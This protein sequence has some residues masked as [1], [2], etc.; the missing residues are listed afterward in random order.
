[1]TIRRWFWL[2]TLSLAFAPFASTAARAQVDFETP[3]DSEDSSDTKTEAK[4]DSTAG[5][6]A[7]AGSSAG[8]STENPDAYL[9][10][11]VDA[12][13]AKLFE[14]TIKLHAEARKIV[15][16]LV[17]KRDNDKL[18]PGAIKTVGAGRVAVSKLTRAAKRLQWWSEPTG[19]DLEARATDLNFQLVA[20]RDYMRAAPAISQKIQAL[21]PKL[22]KEGKKYEKDIPK[23]MKMCDDEKWE[24]AFETF[25]KGKDTLDRVGVWFT[26]DELKPIYDPFAKVQERVSKGLPIVVRTQAVAALEQARQSELAAA[27]AFLPLL[28]QAATAVGQTGKSKFDGALELTG[29]QIVAE[30]GLRWR[31]AQGSFERARALSWGLALTEAPSNSPPGFAPAAKSANPVDGEHSQFTT[32]VLTALSQ[33]I[34][35]DAARVDAAG[36]AALHREYVAAL[37][38]LAAWVGDAGTQNALSAALAGFEAKVPTLAPYRLATSE[39]LRW[40]ER[41]A[42][43]NARARLAAYPA[44]AAVCATGVQRDRAKKIFGLIDESQPR[45]LPKF[46]DPTPAACLSAGPRLK[47]KP[48]SVVDL[49]QG[50]AGT[51]A[52]SRVMYRCQGRATIGVN[53]AA[54][55]AALRKELLTAA[56]E[57]PLSLEAAAAL[58]GAEHGLFAQ[59]GGTI[60]SAELQAVVTRRAT[61]SDA[62]WGLLR[63][64][65]LDPDVIDDPLRECQVCCRLKLEWVRNKYFV[66]ECP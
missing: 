32:Q 42:A 40:R 47:D 66:A 27:K 17:E 25:H 18:G 23:V 50:G 10:V 46:L 49:F 26:P 34:T 12:T 62:D 5:V 19:L 31:A 21:L 36:A 60:T 2:A 22:A 16:D 45:A 9:P 13:V 55:A 37:A 43:A 30:A 52:Q 65:T 38:P 56:G 6:T 54:Q 8:P 11:R 61:A 51:E 53:V 41:T 57:A 7:P 33:L 20:V 3:E 58:Y 59:A 29:P 64:G 39:L 35:A 14:E 24:E 4:A 15:L 63:L 28:T 1:M 44:L 48:V